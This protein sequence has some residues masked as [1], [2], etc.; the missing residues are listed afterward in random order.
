MHALDG[1]LTRGDSMGAAEQ[2]GPAEQ[3]DGQDALPEMVQG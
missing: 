2:Q 3:R 1:Q